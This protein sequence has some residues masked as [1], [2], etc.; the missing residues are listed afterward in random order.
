MKK[1]LRPKIKKSGRRMGGPPLQQSVPI[2]QGAVNAFMAI[3][4]ARTQVMPPHVRAEFERLESLP[5]GR[6]TPE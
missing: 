3:V 2:N 5:E 4:V 1:Q 6:P